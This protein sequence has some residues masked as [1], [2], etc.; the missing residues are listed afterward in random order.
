MAIKAGQGRASVATA[1]ARPETSVQ[2]KAVAEKHVGGRPATVHGRRLGVGRRRGGVV[3]VTRRHD[4]D[5]G[6]TETRSRLRGSAGTAERGTR[7]Q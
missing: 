7:V 6:G 5:K 4:N 1:R 2:R 3:K